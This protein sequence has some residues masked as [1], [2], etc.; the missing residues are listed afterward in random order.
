MG[1]TA[2]QRQTLTW[3]AIAVAG[4][5]LVWLLGPVLTPFIIGCL[6]YT[7]DAADE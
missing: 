1:L 4:F 5:S 6:L 7:S 2:P 3:L